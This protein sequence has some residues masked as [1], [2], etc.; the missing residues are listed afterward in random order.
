MTA[1]LL[2]RSMV[3]RLLFALYTQLASELAQASSSNCQGEP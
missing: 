3:H 1:L 2:A